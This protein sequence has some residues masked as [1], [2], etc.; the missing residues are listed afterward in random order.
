MI[1]G[2]A[3]DLIVIIVR[4]FRLISF[5]LDRNSC[6]N[7]IFEYEAKEA[8]KVRLKIFS[9]GDLTPRDV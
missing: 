7:F 2:S 1:L 4:T 5:A 8:D 9:Y 3:H 6:D